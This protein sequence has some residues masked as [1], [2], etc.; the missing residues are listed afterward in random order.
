MNTSYVEA[1]RSS[2]DLATLLHLDGIEFSE[3]GSECPFCK[4][5]G[6]FHVKPEKGIYNCFHCKEGGDL[7]A[8]IMK[9]DGVPFE[10]ACEILREIIANRYRKMFYLL[11]AFMWR[12]SLIKH[13]VQE[14]IDDAKSCKRKAD[15]VLLELTKSLLTFPSMVDSKENMTA[16]CKR[17]IAADRKRFAEYD[18]ETLKRYGWIGKTYEQ[19]V[20]G[21]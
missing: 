6:S 11:Q 13:E 16:F 19:A 7:F 1:I 2:I 14:V 4:K 8:Y 18:E 10:A 21:E 12:P 9:T 15:P 17:M 3:T 5:P 20:F